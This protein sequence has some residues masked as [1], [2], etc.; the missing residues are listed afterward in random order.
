MSEDGGSPRPDP[1]SMD[2]GDT[3][4]PGKVCNFQKLLEPGIKQ[5]NY[6]SEANLGN[7]RFG[8]YVKLLLHQTKYI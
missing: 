8:L 7:V 6:D 4:P 1:N 2:T 5:L 3:V